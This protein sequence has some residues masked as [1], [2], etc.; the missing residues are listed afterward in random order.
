MENALERAPIR[1]QVWG[2]SLQKA[3][4]FVEGKVLRIIG[5]NWYKSYFL[6]NLKIVINKF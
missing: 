4:G 2:E 5:A 6:N 1:T 3:F